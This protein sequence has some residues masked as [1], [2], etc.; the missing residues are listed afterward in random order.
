LTSARHRIVPSSCSA[1]EVT[2][3]T[4]TCILVSVR[5]TRLGCGGESCGESGAGLPAV[6]GYLASCYIE[7]GYKA[8]VQAVQSVDWLPTCPGRLLVPLGCRDGKLKNQ[9]L[10]RGTLLTFWLQLN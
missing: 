9:Q 5:A 3:E 8:A 10:Q 2:G 1:A 6:L 7:R 4:S